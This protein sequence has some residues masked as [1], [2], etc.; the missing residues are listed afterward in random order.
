MNHNLTKIH[1]HSDNNIFGGSE[2]MLSYILNYKKSE[3]LY[4]VSFSYR[5]SKLYQNQLNTKVDSTIKKFPIKIINHIDYNNIPS[6]LPHLLKSIISRFI[7]FLFFIPIVIYQIIYFYFLLNKINPKILH[8]NNG[9]YPGALSCRTIAIA[10]KIA[11]VQN[12][13]MVVNNLA[14]NYDNFWRLLEYPI[15]RLVV[16]SVSCFITDSKASRKQLKKVLKIS[17][18][19]IK[20]YPNG[21]ILSKK[22][23]NWEKAAIN[24]KKSIKDYFYIGVLARLEPN[25]GHKILI[26][27]IENICINKK[28]YSNKKIKIFFAGIGDESYKDD[29]VRL[30]K[31]KRISENFI[32]LGHINN[33]ENFLYSMD[34]IVQPSLFDETFPCSIIEAM[35]CG[36]L[37]IGS[38][39]A[40][41]PEQIKDRKTGFLVNPGNVR[42]LTKAIIKCLNN[43]RIVNNMGIEAYKRFQQHFSKTKC[44]SNYINLY[45]TLLK[46]KIE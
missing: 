3:N 36:K 26:E 30:L 12:I 46:K 7:N 38:K 43:Y 32:F 11:K 37:V 5:Y 1:F 41:I 19:F 6:W 10:G 23:S 28:N 20:N 44:V 9:G 8:I 42:Q 39:V 31:K 24:F 29:L 27:A 16:N 17:N 15:D 4:K 13:I 2:K 40:G 45:K 22:K 35:A 34:I 33:I 14:V 18:N 21:H 25:K